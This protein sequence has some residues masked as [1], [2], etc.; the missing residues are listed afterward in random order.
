MFRNLKAEMARQ[1]LTG[2][3][4]AVAIGISEKAF[5]NRMS[6][7]TEFLMGELIAIRETFFRNLDIGYLFFE[8]HEEVDL[9]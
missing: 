4:I 5:S 9:L 7:R 2:K 6:G 1:G 3:Q 8:M